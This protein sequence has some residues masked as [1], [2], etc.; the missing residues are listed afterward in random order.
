M[1]LRNDFPLSQTR[2]FTCFPMGSG[3]VIVV[4]KKP[5]HSSLPYNP[6]QLLWRFPVCGKHHGTSVLYWRS[7][8]SHAF[9]SA[10][11]QTPRNFPRPLRPFFLSLWVY[12]L[13]QREKLWVYESCESLP[14]FLCISP[15]PLFLMVERST[16]FPER[17]YY[18]WSPFENFR[19]CGRG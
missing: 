17:A 19:E 18:G 1:N 10:Q 5:S 14:T 13:L 4:L 12:L 6:A 15:Q 7:A 16:F 9:P 8:G 3:F 11:E 2:F